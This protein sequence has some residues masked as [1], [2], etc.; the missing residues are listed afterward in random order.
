MPVPRYD[1]YAMTIR[2]KSHNLDADL[3]DRARRVLGLATET[4]TIHE[5]LRAV[6]RGDEILA[7]IRAA[8][9]KGKKG[10]D[11]FRAEFLEQMRTES[12]RP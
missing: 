11:I 4:E 5:A 7:D 10:R 12:R 8:R 9:S 1:A 6:V 2:R 3:L